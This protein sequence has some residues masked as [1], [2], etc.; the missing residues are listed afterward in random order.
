MIKNKFINKEHLGLNIVPVE[1][2]EEA[3]Q[4]LFEEPIK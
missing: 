4:V 3:L 2:A 1:T